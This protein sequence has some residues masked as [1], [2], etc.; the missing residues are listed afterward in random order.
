VIVRR[1]DGSRP[2]HVIVSAC[3]LRDSAGDVTGASI[4]FHDIT[5]AQ[6]TERKLHQ[7]QKLDAIGQLTGGAAH[8][9]NNMLTVIT[10]TM[11]VLMDAKGD[12]EALR[13]AALVSQAATDTAPARL[14]SKA[15]IA[16]AQYRYKQ[17]NYRYRQATASDARRTYRNQFYSGG[18]G[19]YRAY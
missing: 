9:L 2:R 8:D 18:R 1:A 15:T 7:A 5:D 4:V 10:G 3:P 17:H 11:K 14:R 12:P 13:T 6:E 19:R 16:A